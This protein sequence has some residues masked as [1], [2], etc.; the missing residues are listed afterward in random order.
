MKMTPLAF[1]TKATVENNLRTVIEK[2]SAVGT[3]KHNRLASV[4]K[5]MLREP[6][7]FDGNCQVN[8]EMIG[9]KFEDQL[10]LI[11][12]TTPVANT[13]LLS[14]LTYRFF[15]E[16]D[17]SAKGEFTSE[18]LQYMKEVEDS[19]AAF[20]DEARQQVQFA[21]T[22]MPIS[23][24]KRLLHTKEIENLLAIPK[25]IAEVDSKLE[26]WSQAIETSESRVGRLQ[27]ALA[28]QETAFNFVG[29]HQGFEDLSKTIS[30]ELAWA[31]K[32]LVFFGVLVLIPS[33]SELCFVFLA[34]G[35]VNTLSIYAMIA[36]GIGTIAITLLLLYFFR[37][38]LRKA[39]SCRAQLIQ[40]RLRMSLCRFIQ[41]YAEYSSQVRSKN[42]DAL[43]RF[44]ALIF[45]GI[46]G[47]E[48][49]LPS[50]FDGIDQLAELAK[51][52]R[53]SN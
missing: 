21:K 43:S 30:E 33:L 15:V 22:E 50:T 12:R 10:G 46:V 8:I 4:L 44:E 23:I 31:Q 20:S 35:T 19:L 13:D 53:G 32:A 52:V 27:E 14:S 42:P 38:A 36:S 41:N 16:F 1:F 29:L 18:I 40:I 11:A 25:V 17:L 6:G 34:T 47:I 39:A 49:K 9:G 26:R 5:F 3:Q 45:S 7:N 24:L 51:A 28:K 2:L 37:I 48:E